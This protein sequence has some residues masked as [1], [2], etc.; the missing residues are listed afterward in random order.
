MYYWHLKSAAQTINTSLIARF[1]KYLLVQS[2]ENKEIRPLKSIFD[3]F[4]TV[5][6]LFL[7]FT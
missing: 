2:I 6:W 7:N 4:K 5:C 3:Y 1:L